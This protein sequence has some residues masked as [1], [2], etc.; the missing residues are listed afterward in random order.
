MNWLSIQSEQMTKYSR[1]LL[2]LLLDAACI[3]VSYIMAFLLRFEFSLSGAQTMG[4]FTTYLNNILLITVVKL[5]IYWLGGLYNSIWKYAGTEELVKVF[6]VT[7]AA[8]ATTVTCLHMMQ[9]FLPRGVY[10]I[11]VILDIILIGAAR[12]TYRTIRDMKTPGSFDLIRGRKVRSVSE[13]VLGS[14]VIK[15]MLV[16]AGDAGAAMI[17]EVKMHPENGKKVVV[18]IDDDQSKVG[19][20]IA[21][22]KIAGTRADIKRVARKHGVDEIIIAIPSASKKEITAI[23]AECNKTRC[24]LKIL[25]ALMDLIDEKVSVNTLR[26]VDIEDLLGREAVQVN[27]KEISGYLEGRIVMVTGGGGS[28]GSELCRQ[29]ARFKPRRLI[30]LDIYENS[31]FELSNELRG[32]FPYLEFDVVITSVRDKDR[33]EEVFQR[34]KPHVIFHAAAHKHVPLM[35]GNPKEAVVN[36]IQGT[37]NLIDLS[38][39]YAV[40][41]F[42]LIS[43]DKAVNPTNVMGATKRVAE[44]ML[45]D[46]SGHSRTSYSAV[47]FGNVLGSN[48]SVIPIFRKQIAQGGPV[49]VTHP[50]ICRYFMTIPEAVQ[51]VIQA[52]AMAEGGEIFI[53]DMGDPVK[54]MDLAEN[55][56][57][58]SG[59]VP[60]ED[61]DIKITG[62]R[63]GEKLY[64]EL[65]LAEEGIKTTSHDKIYVG[66]PLPP[67]PALTELLNT[68]AGVEQSVN[69]IVNYSNEEVKQWLN[70]LVPNYN[71]HPDNGRSE[72][73]H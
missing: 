60:Y 26:D 61:I 47:R 23:V 17:K 30:A 20:R 72:K 32:R 65:L 70:C 12:F 9:Q 21:G 45:Q 62:L 13:S 27:L 28:I 42:V 68:D 7:M 44:M 56:I 46:K 25:P 69:E 33:L 36:N 31:V 18:A 54:I 16:G 10:G 29:I 11:A 5:V 63:P 66:H 51:L 24:K 43:T 52:G 22:V 73:R 58:L 14:D 55:I 35:E 71:R 57:R 4:Y 3:N 49:T 59:L 34:Y 53:L 6:F 8:N 39:R 64:E 40:D 50:D 15:V 67:S 1:I 2:L 41:K 48:G 19:K 38:D 37:K